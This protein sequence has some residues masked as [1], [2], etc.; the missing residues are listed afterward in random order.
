MIARYLTRWLCCCVSGGTGESYG[1]TMTNHLANESSPYLL[2]HAGNPVE[3]YPWGDEAFNRARKENKPVLLSI[4]YSACHWCHVMAHESF[5]NEVIA[6]T[7]NEHFINIKV[8]REER[9][10]IDSIYMDAVQAMRGGGGWPLTVF[11][12]PEGNPFYGG[13][14]FPPED[15]QG[16]PGFSKVLLAMADAYHNR[17]G[18]VERTAGQIAK[19]LSRKAHS[20]NFSGPLTARTM[21]IGFTLLQRNFDPEYGGFG[22]APKF[23]QPGLME[24]LLRYSLRSKD[25]KV[26]RMAEFTLEKMARGGIYD[27]IGGGFHR[28]STD[29]RWLVPHFEKMLYDNALLSRLYLHAYRLTGKRIF[30]STAE[31]T[32]DYVLREMSSEHGG[33]YSAQDADSEGVEGKYYVWSEKEF[34]GTLGEEL[35]RKA[36]AYFGITDGGNF[37]GKNILYITGDAAADPAAINKAKK[38]LLKERENRVMPARDEKVLASWNGLM[39]A[40]VAEAAFVLVREDYLNAAVK[41]GTFI[42]DVMMKDGYLNHVHKDGTTRLEGYLQDYAFVIDGM[43]NLHR[44]TFGGKWL[45]LA[46]DLAERM[47][48]QFWDESK[49]TFYDTGSRHDELI[50][51]PA[52]PLDNVLPSGASAATQVLLELAAMTGKGPWNDIAVKSLKSIGPMMAQHPSSFSFWLCALDFNLAG[53]EEIAVIGPRNDTATLE[54][55]HTLN[56]KWFPHMVIAARDPRDTSPADNIAL[57]EN[58]EMVDGRPTVYVCKKHVCKT[59]ANDPDELE[60]QLREL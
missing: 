53:P 25:A 21:E 30:L 56:G 48:E 9:P 46:V 49:K 2:Q 34:T 33:F 26:L 16:M 12:T 45:T 58:R 57:L 29:E 19:T 38:L 54:L 10:D 40:S 1:G 24:F 11:L 52:S 3:W 31:G 55:V 41:S 6:R 47:V 36:G 8:D 13:T 60:A 42:A 37:E 39:L 18:D 4:G 15:R 22:G 5:E 44:A 50:V 7:M 28:Y 35:G 20:M 32:F 51:R 27:Q 59:P 43:L 23:P 14:Y 17:T